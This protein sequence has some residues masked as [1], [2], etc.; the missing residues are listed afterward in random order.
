MASKLEKVILNSPFYNVLRYNKLTDLLVELK[1]NKTK[2]NISFYTAFLNTANDNKMI[3]DVGANKGNKI[4][5]FLQMGFK[6]VALEPEKKAIETL[7]WRF[8]HNKNVEIVE[9]GVS[10][11]IGETPVYITESRSGLNTLS[12]KWVNS[13]GNEK[14]NRWNSQQQYK[15]SYIIKTTTLDELIKAY[16]LPYFIK[17]DVEGFELNVIKGLSVAPAYLSFECNLPEFVAETLEILDLVKNLSD[18]I[19]FRFSLDDALENEN[20]MDLNAIKTIVLSNKY[21]Y[22]EIICKF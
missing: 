14:E 17:I 13:I 4:K 18:K 11:N 12:E 1:G 3:F 20:W 8:A 10:D 22:M 6:V 5:A 21:R 15:I 9:L 19:Q 16:G 7:K 2:K